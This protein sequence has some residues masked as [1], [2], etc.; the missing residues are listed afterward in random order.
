MAKHR[1][2]FS[3]DSIG[4]TGN[5][6]KGEAAPLEDCVRSAKE[7]GYDGV[8]L[9]AR[10]PH[11]VPYAWDRERAKKLKGLAEDL[12]VP[13]TGLGAFTNFAMPNHT[14][15]DERHKEY[16]YLRCLCRLAQTV[17]T[18]YIRIFAGWIGWFNPPHDGGMIYEKSD[19]TWQRRRYDW[20]I[21]GLREAAKIAQDHGVVL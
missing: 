15:A 19:D 16:L 6:Y 18:N 11:F 7:F 8:E 5:F 2:S 21:E 14:Q 10:P 17:G 12:G 13:I 3:L 1:F 9:C 4:Y 20:A